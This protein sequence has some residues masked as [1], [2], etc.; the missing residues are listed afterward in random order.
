MTEKPK[1][2]PPPEIRAAARQFARWRANRGAGR[3]R[4]PE[5]LWAAAVRAARACSVHRTARALGLSHQALAVRCKPGATD[6]ARPATFVELQ[7]ASARECL[8][9][10]EPPSG[11]RVRIRVA[12]MTPPELAALT[13]ALLKTDA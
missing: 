2:P 13:A 3:P 9:E 8:V 11:G 10:I 7:A 1:D 6:A 5:S 4:I 12:G